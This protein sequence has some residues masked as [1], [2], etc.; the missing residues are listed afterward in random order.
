[1]VLVGARSPAEVV[2]ARE[3]QRLRVRADLQVEVT[4]DQAGPGWWGQVGVVTKLVARARFDPASALALVCGPEVMMRFTA[5]ALVDRGLVP[6]AIRISVERNMK[7][8]VGWCGHCQLAGT[9]IC[10]DGPVFGY[11]TA[12]P[13]LAARE[14]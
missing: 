6:A 11:D 13:L 10:K 7:C 2:F 3:L 9:F 4:A 1:M 5:L 12:A 8:A 14:R